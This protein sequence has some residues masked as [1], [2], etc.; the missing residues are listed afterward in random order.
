MQL[1]KY[2]PSTHNANRH[3]KRGLGALEQSIRE[4]GYV[5]P[6][7]VAADGESLDG[8]ARLEVVAELMGDAEPLVVHHDGKR[9]VVMV[10]DDVPNA[11]TDMAKR[12]AI[13]A[14]RIAQID[15]EWDPDVLLTMPDELIESLFDA[16]ELEGMLE[17]ELVDATS[18]SNGIGIGGGSAT[19]TAVIALVETTV[20]EQ[21][22]RLTGVANRG[23]ALMALCREYIGKHA[24][25]G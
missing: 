7:T 5:A 2:R 16:S 19:I 12:I 22:L 9:P 13:R 23:E 10:R 25:E 11:S 20:F 14:N 8:S 17:A 24:K 1:G 15:L 21:A 3:T 4:D 18:A 6:I